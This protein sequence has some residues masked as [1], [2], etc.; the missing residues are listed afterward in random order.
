MTTMEAT[1]T[2]AD[3]IDA[4]RN[5]QDLLRQYADYG[6]THRRTADEVID[7][8]SAAGMFR[9]LAPRR[10]NGYEVD[11]GT[12]L[13][14]TEILGEA[15]G[16][17]AWLV[18]VAASAVWSLAH[19]PAQALD[20]ILGGDPDARLAG[21]AAG[22]GTGRV[23]DGG[24]IVTGRW[25]YA[26]GSLHAS[27]VGVITTLGVENPEPT[28][29]FCL[30]PIADVQIED[31]WYTAGLRGTGSNTLVVTDV[32]VPEH[33]IVPIS[34]L[35]E[36]ST[37]RHGPLYRLP[38]RSV[39][40]LAHLGPILG[41][42]RAALT[43][44]IEATAVKGIPMTVFDTQ[45][46]SVGVQLQVADAALKLQT[47]RLHAHSVAATLMEHAI[48]AQPLD[49]RYRAQAAAETAHAA[50]QILAAANGLLS[51]HGSGGLSDANPL[52]RMIRDISTGTR[53]A[54]LN[55]AVNSEVFGKALL[56]VPDQIMPV[57]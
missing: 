53:H 18:G 16:S 5:L 12:F 43:Q 54:A 28:I 1:P 33:R 22:A 13:D 44:V 41:M 47:A 25:S 35:T 29:A 56:G 38:M 15:D 7:A 24:V 52:Q 36:Q 27:W 21:G 55:P 10:Y 51:V 11:L 19:A 50:Q 6:D 37:S 57:L 32:F 8:L 34:W 39:G 26:S 2:R 9:L 49:P 30:M 48:A 20:E 31:T 45:R 23:V 46:E 42:G 40:V 17:A 14:I 3:L 4:A